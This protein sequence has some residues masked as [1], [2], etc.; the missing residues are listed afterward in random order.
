MQESKQ[1]VIE[2]ISLV[3]TGKKVYMFPL[4]VLAAV[5][6]MVDGGINE[7]YYNTKDHREDYIP[8]MVTGDFDSAPPEVLQFYKEKVSIDSV[9]HENH[10]IVFALT[11]KMPQKPASQNVVCLCRLLNIFAILSNLFF[12]YRQT[13]WTLIRLLLE[14][15]S[16][17]GP[18][19]LQK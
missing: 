7:L 12:A 9:V 17:L 15:Q 10:H 16:D 6:A 11:L 2:D 1:E 18:H 13:V 19:C 4:T 5:K 8:D 3:K 14:E